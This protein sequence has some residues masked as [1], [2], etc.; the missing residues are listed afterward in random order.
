MKARVLNY[1]LILAL[2]ITATL[3][4]S[5]SGQPAVTSEASLQAAYRHAIEDAR[6][7]EPDEISTNLVAI[8]GYYKDL[9]WDGKPGQSRVLVVTWTSWDGYNS[10]VGESVNITRAVWVT[11]VPEVKDFIEK[12]HL[13]DGALVLRMEQLLGLPP[14]NGKQWFVEMWVSPDD[15]FRPSPD[16][17]ITDHEAELDFRWDA[18]AEYRQWF[19]NLQTESY[20]EN[21][22]PWTR[23]GYTYDWG[24]SSSEVGL[25]EF[26]IGAGA[27]AIIHSVANTRDYFK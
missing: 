12:N 19:K 18:G 26:V 14:H 9:I 22:Y 1:F 11:V 21:G 27:S 7:A 2:C 23:L 10:E 25:S 3:V 15:L 5:C 17:E 24:N 8:T 16:P 20:G 13:S 6:L 4:T